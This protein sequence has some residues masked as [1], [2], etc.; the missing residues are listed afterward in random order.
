MCAW[1]RILY[2]INAQKGGWQ[3]TQQIVG[4]GVSEGQSGREAAVFSF[5]P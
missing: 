2:D 4:T 5:A 1:I 3:V